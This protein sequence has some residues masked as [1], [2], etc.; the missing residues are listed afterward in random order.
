MRWFGL[1]IAPKPK[2]HERFARQYSY[3]T[4]VSPNFALLR[5]SSPSA[6]S[7]QDEQ[8]HTNTHRCTRI[9]SC[10]QTDINFFTHIDTNTHTYTCTYTYIHTCYHEPSR[11]QPQFLCCVCCLCV[12]VCC[13]S[14]S[15]QHMCENKPQ[16]MHIYSHIVCD[17][18]PNTDKKSNCFFEVIST[19]T[20]FE[21]E[22]AK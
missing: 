18:T 11:T 12:S 1:S 6:G 3:S 13:L 21:F 4:R 2:S 16:H 7:W 15:D 19:T 10:T 5:D 14:A 22:S 8:K 17:R 9:H 20:K